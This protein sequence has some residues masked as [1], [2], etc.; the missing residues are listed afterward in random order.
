MLIFRIVPSNFFGAGPHCRAFSSAQHAD[1]F[2]ERKL[3]SFSLAH[4]LYLYS[5]EL[6][7]LIDCLK[8]TKTKQY[9]A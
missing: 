3:V 5:Y 6:I 1:K 8:V 7:R 4:V 2:T 9:L